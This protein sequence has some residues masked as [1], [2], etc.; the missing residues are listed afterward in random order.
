[1]DVRVMLKKTMKLEQTLAGWA[2]L[3]PKMKFLLSRDSI[4]HSFT[5]DFFYLNSLVTPYF[6]TDCRFKAAR[7]VK[8]LYEY[9]YHYADV[10]VYFARVYISC[11]VFYSK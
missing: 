4:V 3:P 9:G 7:V 8:P 2:S 5:I 11:T 6:P 10:A 1:M